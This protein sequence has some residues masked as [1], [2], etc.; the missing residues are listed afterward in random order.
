LGLPAGGRDVSNYLDRRVSSRIAAHF[1]L[2]VGVVTMVLVSF[3][4]GAR[5]ECNFAACPP[6]P[7][8]QVSVASANSAISSEYTAFD[9]G[10]RFLQSL[11]EH[12]SSSGGY[13]L[14]NAAGG[15][16][17]D[18]PQLFRSWVESYGLWS[19]TAAQGD[20]AGDHRSSLG[21]VAGVGMNVAPGAW[22]GV[23]VDQS[24]TSIDVPAAMQHGIFDL[25]QLG[26]NGSYE[27]GPW[28]ISGAVV[29]GIGSVGENRD[30]AT[31][32]AGASY[33]GDLWGAISELSYFVG[34]GNT[35]IV[36][37]IGFD[38]LQTHTETY[39]ESGESLDIASVPDTVFDRTRAL[40]GAEI[41]HSW[42]VDTTLIDLSGYG[43]FIDIVSQ[44]NPTLFVTSATGAE[45]PSLIQGPLEG[46]YGADAGATLTL[47]LTQ[48]SRV[49]FG[50]ES[51][52]RDG[53][54]AY[55]GT[56]GGEVKW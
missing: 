56:I 31:G 49:Y 3:V 41:G 42:M 21:G 7:L 52:F 14:P 48:L 26:L 19:S 5:S 29:R 24:H 20:F 53:Y 32:P 4:D 50:F 27:S 44:S 1:T 10:G 2:A 38:W 40:A 11:A 39:T 36:P 37:K 8:P 55:G 16:A 25:T 28:T 43:R 45:S 47:R 46:Q 18:Q 6:P 12:A 35:R 33:N 15:G 9:L 54:Q 22:V 30:T 34:L 17:G 51:H 23:S 13:A